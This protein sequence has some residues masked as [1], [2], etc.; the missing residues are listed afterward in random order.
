MLES[1]AFLAGS[2]FF[3][4]LILISGDFM[5]SKNSKNNKRNNLGPRNISLG[6]LIRYCFPIM[7]IV[8]ILHRASG[9]VLFLLIPFM[10]YL[11]EKLKSSAASFAQVQSGFDHC[12]VLKILTWILLSAL[13]YHLIAGVKHLFM[14][15]GFLEEKESAKI[16]SI[17]ILILGFIGIVLLGA[18]LW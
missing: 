3:K 8:S 5:V 16:S 9:F 17:F 7:A 4:F 13:W 6:N 10:L 12:W 11:L 14:D 1:A 2:D 18:W 15:L